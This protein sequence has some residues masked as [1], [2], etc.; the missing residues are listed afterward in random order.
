MYLIASDILAEL[1]GLSPGLIGVM[2]G[3]GVTLW[4]LG[5][6]SH[7]FWIVLSATVLAGVFGLYEAASRQAQPLV[8]SLL[9]AL[10][11]GLLALALIRLFAFIGCG[12]AG[13]LLAETLAPQLEQPMI[14]FLVCGLLGVLLFRWCVM[15]LTSLAGSALLLYAGLAFLNQRGKLDAVAWSDQGAVLL[16]WI[17]GLMTVMGFAFQSLLERR[18]KRRQEEEEPDKKRKKGKEHVEEYRGLFWKAG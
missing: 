13:F 3:V 17:C 18:R 9:L 1:C 14:V 6:W 8:T 12:L 2:A 4:L 7:R 10:A 15:G 11:A 16:N 5:W